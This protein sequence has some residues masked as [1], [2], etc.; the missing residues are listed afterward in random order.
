MEEK[1]IAGAE[2]YLGIDLAADSTSA[3]ISC[4]MPNVSGWNLLRVVV[5]AAERMKSPR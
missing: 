5:V 3:V 1:E 2:T 4:Q